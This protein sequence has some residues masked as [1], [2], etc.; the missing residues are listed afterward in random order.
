MKE[1][2]LFFD[3]SV[4]LTANPVGIATNKK[5]EA[6]LHPQKNPDGVFNEQ[7]HP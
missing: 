4:G 2:A 7:K 3:M 5:H 1:G 6:K